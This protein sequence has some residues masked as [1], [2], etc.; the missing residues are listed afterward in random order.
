VAWL[1]GDEDSAH[2]IQLPAPA[3]RAP[4]F[5]CIRDRQLVAHPPT[6]PPVLLVSRRNP[7]LLVLRGFGHGER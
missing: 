3:P 6:R 2:A 1:W 5:A 7:R 4:V